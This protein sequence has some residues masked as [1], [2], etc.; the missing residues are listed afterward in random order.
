[1]PNSNNKFFLA[2][3]IYLIILFFPSFPK[4]FY[5]L[6]KKKGIEIEIS[7]LFAAQLANIGQIKLGFEVFCHIKYLYFFLRLCLE[8]RQAKKRLLS[9]PH[10]KRKKRI[11]IMACSPL[12]QFAIIPLILTHIGN[13]YLSFTYGACT[14]Y[15]M[16]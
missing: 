6:F 16:V 3:Q 13:F 8:K 14:Y 7:A 5:L 4:S 10:A 1:M 9:L 11:F 2:L 15:S 12:E